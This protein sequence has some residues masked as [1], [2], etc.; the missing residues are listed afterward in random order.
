MTMGAQGETARRRIIDAAYEFFYRHGYG[1]AGVDAIAEAAGV[2]KRTLYHHFDS[3]DALLTA[4]LEDQHEL[5]LKRFREWLR[6]TAEPIAMLEA[7]F[8]E[9]KRWSAKPGWQGSGFSRAAL[10]LA[11]LPGH[12]A[13]LA[14]HRH[15][16]ALEQILRE[17]LAKHAQCD[18]DV[19]AR[20][21]LAVV[22]GCMVLILVHGDPTYADAGGAAARLLVEAAAR[23]GAGA[24]IR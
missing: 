11:D 6:P 3:K 7:L 12:P 24:Q 14:A 10:E 8:A 1:R 13:R 18:A 20:Q 4:V 23:R 21:V 16:A 5:V 9:L 19:L 15:K 22:E 17:E 2:T